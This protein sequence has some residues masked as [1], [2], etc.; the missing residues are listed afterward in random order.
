MDVLF[1]SDSILVPRQTKMLDKVEGKDPELFHGMFEHS[2]L[3][4]PFRI[5]TKSVAMEIGNARE[6]IH[7]RA[8]SNLSRGSLS[9]GNLD[10]LVQEKGAVEIER[11]ENGEEGLRVVLIRSS[12]EPHVEERGEG[13]MSMRSEKDE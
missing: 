11:V 9:L 10:K 1:S 7:E 13:G 8:G 12:K 2:T 3:S 4:W 5:S 6:L